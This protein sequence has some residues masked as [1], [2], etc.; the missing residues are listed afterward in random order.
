MRHKEPRFSI[1]IPCYNEGKYLSETLESIKD[2]DFS[3]DLEVIVVDNNCTDNTV[4]I[5]KEYG[6]KIITEPNPGVCWA[7]QAGT[8]AATGEIIVSTDADTRFSR[9][10]LSKIDKTFRSGDYVAVSGPCMYSD[11]P[12][13]GKFYP[14]FLFGAV[15]LVKR[16]LGY[17]FYVTATNIA[18][19]KSAWSGYDTFQTQGGD[20][21]SLLHSLREKGMVAFDNDNPV[22]T[23]G[24]RLYRGLF[25]NVFVSFFI[26]YLMAY[27]VNKLFHR[28]VIGTA[29]AYRT[30]EPRSS[31][32]TLFRATAAASLILLIATMHLPG[33]DTILQQA[34]ET[35]ARV[36]KIIRLHA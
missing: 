22:Y 24:R 19:R 11:G 15:D 3:G 9:S 5:A 16:I 23:S 35:V 4:D 33:H 17:P 20:E 34:H 6:A 27:Y 12:W 36:E 26:H 14:K 2:Q 31:W 13:W 25:Y 28:T 32:A 18:F 21:L 1:V 29:P 10:W 7:R 8:E 30:V